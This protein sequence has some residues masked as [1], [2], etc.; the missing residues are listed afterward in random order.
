MAH[1][2]IISTLLDE[3]M[4]WTLLYFRR[5][6]FVTRKMEVKYVRPVPVEAPLHV[7]GRMV[8]GAGPSKAGARADIVDEEG[9]LL[10]RGRPSS[11]CWRNGSSTSY[12]RPQSTDEGALREILGR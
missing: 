4:A 9:R 5:A 3:V 8:D 6:F 1:G 2:G 11:P 12:P 10:A 7:R